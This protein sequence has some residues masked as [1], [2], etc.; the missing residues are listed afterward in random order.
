MGLFLEDCEMAL[1]DEKKAAKK[2]L[3]DTL[4]EGHIITPD[5]LESALDRQKET[6]EKKQSFAR[7]QR[8]CGKKHDSFAC[9]Q[10]LDVF[11]RTLIEALQC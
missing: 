11:F 1:W 7:F 3:G 6:G 5:Q 4:V 10:S 8:L 2:R 9:L